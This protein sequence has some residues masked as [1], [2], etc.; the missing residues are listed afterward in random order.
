[1][2]RQWF[3]EEKDSEKCF[4]SCTAVTSTL[5]P[6][7]QHT[8]QVELKVWLVN[9]CVTSVSATG[10]ILLLQIQQYPLP[11]Q[12]RYTERMR[13]MHYTVRLWPFIF[14]CHLTCCIRR[15]SARSVAPPGIRVAAAARVKL[16]A[17]RRL[18]LVNKPLPQTLGLCSCLSC[19]VG[20]LTPDFNYG[21]RYCYR[22]G[23]WLRLPGY[24][25]QPLI[26][27]PH[28][29]RYLYKPMLLQTAY[30]P[31]LK[32]MT[33]AGHFLVHISSEAIN[34]VPITA[35]SK[36]QQYFQLNTPIFATQASSISYLQTTIGSF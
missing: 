13:A 10:I 9:Q 19:C 22:L 31:I 2:E 25:P 12:D 28:G 4:L 23:T 26:W 33:L 11:I 6:V 30:A 3:A 17:C 7:P 15:P 24:D 21:H 32:S 29:L 34:T 27:T 1:M 5:N 14:N 35:V 16:T 36:S 18:G 20:T 8:Q